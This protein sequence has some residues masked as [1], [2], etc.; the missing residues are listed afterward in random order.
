[1]HGFVVLDHLAL[2]DGEEIQPGTS[3]TTP[4]TNN[5]EKT[6]EGSTPHQTTQAV[7]NQS[8]AASFTR[9]NQS[10]TTK[11]VNTGRR[12]LGM[13]SKPG[14]KKKALEIPLVVSDLQ[15]TSLYSINPFCIP[16]RYLN[17][18]VKPPSPLK[19]AVS[20]SASAAPTSSASAA[21]TSSDA[22]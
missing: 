3:G 1:M 11:A 2:S 20:T 4:S 15:K 17:P 14:R 22:A 16:I 6:A 7:S 19:K 21:P 18:K 8:K 13:R 5:S 12:Y 9:A 10:N